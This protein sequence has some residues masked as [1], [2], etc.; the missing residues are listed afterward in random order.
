[1][2]LQYALFVSAAVYEERHQKILHL[3]EAFNNLSHDEEAFCRLLAIR[4]GVKV[5]AR[6]LPLLPKVSSCS[7]GKLF[8]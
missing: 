6:L 5:V 4:K 7:C 8:C 1:M 3:Y 2:Y